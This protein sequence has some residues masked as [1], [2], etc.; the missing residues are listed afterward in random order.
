[1]FDGKI[2]I[3][4]RLQGYSNSFWPFDWPIIPWFVLVCMGDSNLGRFTVDWKRLEITDLHSSP[5]D[6]FVNRH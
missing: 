5:I 2:V 6:M 4:E 1:M 3:F